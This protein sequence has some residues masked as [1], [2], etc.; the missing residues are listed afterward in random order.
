M[1]GLV[2]PRAGHPRLFSKFD[3]TWMAGRRQAEATPF[4]ER[5]CPAMTEFECD[6][7]RTLKSNTAW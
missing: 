4:F 6:H 2:L 7:F 5:L 3:K 1:P